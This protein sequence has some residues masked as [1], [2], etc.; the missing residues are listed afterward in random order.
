MQGVLVLAARV[1][2]LTFTSFTLAFTET[3]ASS[4]PFITLSD[5]RPG[6]P[7]EL[8]GHAG[9]FGFGRSR[10]L[11]NVHF[12]HVSLHRNRRLIVAVH[13]DIRSQTRYS[14]RAFWTC[15]GFWFW[16]LAFAR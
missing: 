1:R 5:R 15:R 6:T 10:S 12:V 13:H 8:F 11:A 9:G 16:P 4:S 14:R 2:S 3:A 7:E